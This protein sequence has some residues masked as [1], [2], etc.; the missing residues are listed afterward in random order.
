[1]TQTIILIGIQFVQL[2]KKL[3]MMLDSLSAGAAQPPGPPQRVRPVANYRCMKTV[4]RM[5]FVQTLQ[6]VKVNCFSGKQR[7]FYECTARGQNKISFSTSDAV[8]SSLNGRK[9]PGVNSESSE[10]WKRNHFYWNCVGHVWGNCIQSRANIIQTAFHV[11]ECD[12]FSQP[13]AASG[14]GDPS[15]FF[16]RGRRHDEF[17]ALPKWRVVQRNQSA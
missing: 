5:W 10:K 9:I 1:M 12:L 8:R 13:R 4:L 3:A 17:N 2:G 16:P 6:R 15:R 7:G 11:T 14:T